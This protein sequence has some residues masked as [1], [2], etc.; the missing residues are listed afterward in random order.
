M[1][2][3]M[4]F[5]AGCLERAIRILAYHDHSQEMDAC[6]RKML[7][8]P[9]QLHVL[10]QDAT[11]KA[12]LEE[13]SL[14]QPWSTSSWKLEREALAVMKGYVAKCIDSVC[15]SHLWRAT[16]RDAGRLTLL[17][18]SPRTGITI[19][20]CMQHGKLGH[21]SKT[22]TITTRTDNAERGKPYNKQCELKL[23]RRT[24]NNNGMH[25]NRNTVY[26]FF[27]K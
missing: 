22:P 7:W 12:N 11:K 17:H 20:R 9:T 10:L 21:G 1:P 5:V 6:K 25:L 16:I 4:L 18:L 15:L 8:E 26:P 27:V 14:A 19:K 24:A 23:M 2:H 13:E 3:I